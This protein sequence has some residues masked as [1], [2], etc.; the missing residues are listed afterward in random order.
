MDRFGFPG[1]V[2]RLCRTRVD[3]IYVY[4]ANFAV[5]KGVKQNDHC[6]LFI[7]LMQELMGLCALLAGK[8]VCMESQ[9]LHRKCIVVLIAAAEISY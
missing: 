1:G 3:E 4:S 6:L 5:L 7:Y 9:A 2:R 8:T